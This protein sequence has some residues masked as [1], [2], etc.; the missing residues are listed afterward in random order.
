LHYAVEKA[1]RDV[2]IVPDIKNSFLNIHIVSDRLDS[3]QGI[4]NLELFDFSGNKLKS[5]N[6]HLNFPPNT[7][8]LIY[9]KPITE[10]I[11]GADTTQTVLRCQLLNPDNY[12][13]AEK[14]FYFAKPKNLILEKSEIKISF[15]QL[16]A[17]Q[18]ELTIS[19]DRLAKNLFLQTDI[20][21]SF[22]RNYFDI[23]PHS[24]HTT[25]F[26]SEKELAVNELKQKLKSISLSD[27]Y[28]KN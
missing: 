2:I 1:F 13:L 26:I 25:I 12:L 19:T 9:T 16:T 11:E 7:S 14:L 8:S 23:L 24:T 18:I 28:L 22:S 15:R 10:F 21:G 27:S 5:E 6:Q 20:N 3:I 17:N 4:L